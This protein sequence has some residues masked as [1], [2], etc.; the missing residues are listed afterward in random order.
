MSRNIPTAAQLRTKCHNWNAQHPVGA[1]IA[2]ESTRGHGET[3]RGK[4]YSEVMGGH[5][6]VSW[7]EGKSGCVD[8]NQC[9]ALKAE[10]V[11]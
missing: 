8:L 9:M 4:S 11:S 3:H 10:A 2:F 5:S 1:V 6:A 7:L